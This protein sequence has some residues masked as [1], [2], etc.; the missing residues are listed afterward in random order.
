MFLDGSSKVDENIRQM[1]FWDVLNGVSRRSWSGNR[2][3]RQTIE[4]A[5]VQEDK[6]RVT[7]PNDLAEDCRKKLSM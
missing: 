4:R 2:N 3:A 1:L 5:M 6:L 7:I